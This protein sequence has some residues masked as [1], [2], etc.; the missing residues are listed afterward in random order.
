MQYRQLH[1]ILN[2]GEN[3]I[4]RMIPVVSHQAGSDEVGLNLFDV[5]V[6]SISLLQIFDR[7]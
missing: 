3:R 5:L 7:G 6:A 4:L 1:N 2:L